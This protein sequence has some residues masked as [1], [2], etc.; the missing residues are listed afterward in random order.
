MLVEK[1]FALTCAEANGLVSLAEEA[2]TPL[3]VAQNYRYMRA[4]RTARRI[5][6]DGVV[7]DLRMVTAS[8]YRVPHDMAASLARLP[9]TVLWGMAIHHLDALRS[10]LGRDVVRVVADSFNS[11]HGETPAG[12]SLRALLTFDGDLRV[13]YTATYESSGHQFFEGGQEFYL[14]VVGERGTLHVLHRWL[15]LCLNGRL[16]RLVPRGART[17]S[18]ESVLLNQLHRSIRH[19]ETADASGKDNL[20]TMAVVDACR[21]SSS[22]SRWVD[23]QERT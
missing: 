2:G 9:D 5:V 16:P 3:L 22:E 18:E 15:V 13:S 17:E 21:Q 7:G 14:R 6:Q 4:F 8:Y 19:G 11:I 12:A 10:V 23:V 20:K 1:P